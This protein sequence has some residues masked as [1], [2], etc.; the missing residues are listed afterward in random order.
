MAIRELVPISTLIFAMVVWVLDVLIWNTPG[1]S[2]LI[3]LLLPLLLIR[4]LWGWKNPELFK[5]RIIGIAIL[6][7]TMALVFTGLRINSGLARDRAEA[8]IK[9]CEQFK[10]ATGKYPERLVE[11][12]PNYMEKIPRTS[13]ALLAGDFIYLS[14][15]NQHRLVYTAIP[16]YG[17]S[18]YTFE[19]KKWGATD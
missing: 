9:A 16:P 13:Y 6:V 5:K 7:V 8:I 2:A 15:N 19:E 10:G 1:L 12:V 3:L 18:Y 11:L 17:R 4:G 14:K